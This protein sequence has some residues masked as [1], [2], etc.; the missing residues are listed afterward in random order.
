MDGTQVLLRLRDQ[1]WWLEW[2]DYD[3]RVQQVDLLL[4][5]SG[6]ESFIT[7]H[8]EALGWLSVGQARFSG[9]KYMVKS[10]T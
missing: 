8:A 1:E 2:P 7:L 3:I 10:G 5:Q 9:P 6:K 4:L